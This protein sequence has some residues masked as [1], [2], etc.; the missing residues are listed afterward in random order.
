MLYE[1]AIHYNGLIWDTCPNCGEGDVIIN[2]AQELNTLSIWSG[3]QLT[4]QIVF[5]LAPSNLGHTLPFLKKT[6]DKN[7]DI[8]GYLLKYRIKDTINSIL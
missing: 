1:S 8:L 2:L 4:N 3:R 5:L 7:S 6:Y